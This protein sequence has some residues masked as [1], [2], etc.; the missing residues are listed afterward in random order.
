MFIKYFHFDYQYIAVADI[1]KTIVTPKL[2]GYATHL[3][4]K[5]VGMSHPYEFLF[6]YAY[7]M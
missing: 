5:I 7:N 6:I 1:T 4:N 3:I 2:L